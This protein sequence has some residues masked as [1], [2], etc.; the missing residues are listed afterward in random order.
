M[1]TPNVIVTAPN[2][3]IDGRSSILECSATTVGGITSR[4]DIIWRK[5]GTE[6]KRMLGVNV[7]FT[8]DHSTVYTGTYTIS[9]LITT[10]DGRE[11]QCELLINTSPPVIA[12]G[13]VILNVLGK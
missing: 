8:V 6:L 7:S 12:T 1:P 13:S 9:K 10:D 4:V 3:Q 2:T 5:D 11:Y